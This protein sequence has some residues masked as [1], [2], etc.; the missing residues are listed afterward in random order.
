MGCSYVLIDLFSLVQNTTFLPTLGERVEDVTVGEF[1]LGIPLTMDIKGRLRGL[2]MSKYYSLCVANLCQLT[3][4]LLCLLS[5]CS[6]I[7][8][9]T[10]MW[11]PHVSYRAFVTCCVSPT[12]SLSCT[13]L[14]PVLLNVVSSPENAVSFG[15]HPFHYLHNPQPKEPSQYCLRSVTGNRLVS[16]HCI[17]VR[18]VTGSR[19]VRV[20]SLLV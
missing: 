14:P 8:R 12:L 4:W 18:S 13:E 19:L 20:Y 17:R 11:H 9:V 16:Q 2:R 3:C 5:H 10:L 7:L 6:F 1:P 15:G